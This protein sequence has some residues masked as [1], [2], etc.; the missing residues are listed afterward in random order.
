MV[1]VFAVVFVVVVI[2]ADTEAVVVMD[3]T[4]KA[5][6][7]LATADI[8]EDKQGTLGAVAWEDLAS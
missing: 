6:I 2:A 8:V 7:V 3:I 5:D 4:D 1:V